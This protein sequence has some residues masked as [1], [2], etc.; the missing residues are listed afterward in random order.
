MRGVRKTAPFLCSVLGLISFLVAAADQPSMPHSTSS[1]E[2]KG[3]VFTGPGSPPLEPSAFTSMAKVGGNFVALVPEATVYRQNLQVVYDFENQW[4]GEKTDA[5]LQG[6]RLARQANLKVMLKP[7]LAVGWDLSGWLHPELDIHDAASRTAYREGV[8][9]FVA[10]QKDLSTGQGPW[11]GDFDVR[12]DEDWPR[13]AESYRSFILEYARLAEEHSVELFCIGT[14]LKKIALQRPEYWRTLIRDV[15]RVYRGPLVYAANWDRYD[16]IEFWDRLDYIGIDAYFPV[17]ESK[18]PTTDEIENGWKEHVRRIEKLHARFGKPVILTEW[19]YEDEDF[20]GKEPWVM[21][22]PA[23]AGS[24]PNQE[25]QANAYEGTLRSTWSE[26]WMH[27]VFVW[28]WS[29]GTGPSGSL[30]Y[31]P[32]GKRAEDV[33]E[34]WFAK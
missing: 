14:E 8:L 23:G 28:R 7:H 29:P 25:G 18:T 27:G 11:R 20:A 22:R 19:G 34:R 17:S 5:T 16:D 4:Y 30:S 10:T 33:L 2:I 9:A 24:S 21:G 15:R 32:R 6:I 13:F 12:S 1:P 3:F 31:S 26:P